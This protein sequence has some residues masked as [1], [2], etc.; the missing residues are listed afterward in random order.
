VESSPLRTAREPGASGRALVLHGG[1]S[2]GNAWEIGVIAGLLEAGLDVTR[3]DL[4]IG[5]SA[6]ATAAAQITSASPR[7]LFTR[8][9]DAPSPQGAQNRPSGGRASL[10]PVTDHLERTNRVISE[11]KN[12]ADMRRRMGAAALEMDAG[13]DGSAQ[14]RWRAVVAGRLPSDQWPTQEVLVTA[15]VAKTGEPVV[16]DRHSGIG[17]VDAVAASTSNGFGVPPFGIGNDRFIDGG[18]RRNENADLAA[19]C[20]RVLILS[21][22]GGRSRHPAEWRMQLAVQVEELRAHGSAVESVLPNA[23]S[24]QAFGANMMDP[25]TRGPSARAGYEQ[26]VAER[27]RIARLWE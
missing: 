22:F 15:V 10:G 1:G 2:A 16:F 8:I 12:A 25:T 18:Y 4:I 3:A 21:P 14:E 27:G 24:R 19:G 9:L 17:L 13:S 7:D 26:A 11:A 23:S 5:T 20:E 6:G